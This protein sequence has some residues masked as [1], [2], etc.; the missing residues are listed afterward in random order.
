[1]NGNAGGA[2]LDKLVID[3]GKPLNGAIRIQ[4]AKNAAL[5]ILAACML[6]EG[7]HILKN[8]P[9]LTDIEVMLNILKKLG[10]HA[11]HQADQIRIDTREIHSTYIPEADMK[12]MR[13]SIFCMGPLLARFG[14]V[15]VYQP[16]GCAIGERK[17]D[18][19]L[20]GLEALGVK[21]EQ[22]SHQIHAYVNQLIGTDI[23]LDFP[24]VG[25]TE[26]VM[27]AAVFAK[28]MT[29]I[30]NAAR[31]PEIQD[32]QNF[33]NQMG[34]DIMGAG[35]HTITIRGTPLLS[36]C[37]YRIMPD[38][39]VAGTMLIAAAAT[40]GSIQLQHVNN[41]HLTS[42][43]HVLK[44]MG[45]QVHTEQDTI[46]MTCPKR[47]KS[48]ERIVTSPYPA[49]PTDLQSPILVLLSLADG[50]S[51]LKETIFEGRFQHVEEL[52]RM[53]AD[54]SVHYNVARIK[55]V[56]RLYGASV[57][58]RDLRAGAAL[59]IAG[60]AAQGKTII[61]QIHHI[62]RGYDQIENMFTQ[63]GASIHRSALVPLE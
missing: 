36:P 16:G 21:I 1:M 8:V 26:N 15:T 33:L 45:A 31:E 20:K 4:G 14:H 38:R 32:L 40:R 11:D 44:R 6:A 43:L 18:I 54:V 34:A 39:I 41:S 55:G 63:I 62:D 30:H 47:P 7:T 13:S 22:T 42:V 56:P 19:H 37:T 58:A 9:R 52:S 2:D 48:I 12:Q 23:V 60:L 5:P 59:V 49:F 10:C 50:T 35:T 46:W 28:G 29:N 24:S 53:G 57:E 25:A 61:D 27:M 17:I 3:G 51:I